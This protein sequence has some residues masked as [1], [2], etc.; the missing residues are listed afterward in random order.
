MRSKSLLILCVLSLVLVA[1]VVNTF[2]QL[3]LTRLAFLGFRHILFRILIDTVKSNLGSPKEIITEKII[4]KAS[5]ELEI[6]VI[7]IRGPFNPI[8]EDFAAD[9]ANA[10]NDEELQ[11]IAE[12]YASRLSDTLSAEIEMVKTTRLNVEL[13]VSAVSYR[14][15]GQVL[16]LGASTNDDGHIQHWDLGR[17]TLMKRVHGHNGSVTA[18]DYH[19]N[20]QIYASGS[21]DDTVHIRRVSNDSLIVTLNH[22][23]NVKPV[24]FSRDGNYLLAL[25]VGR[26][27]HQALKVWRASDWSQLYHIP[28]AMISNDAAFTSDSQHVIYS[29]E[30]S[31]EFLNLQT[32]RVTRTLP[33]RFSQQV[34]ISSDGRKLAYP[35]SRDLVIWD[36][37]KNERITSINDA[38]DGAIFGLEFLPNDNLL[39]SS[40]NRKLIKIWSVADAEL[41]AVFQPTNLFPN[42]IDVSPNGRQ[43]ALGCYNPGI[44]R[45]E[46]YLFDVA[47]F[48]NWLSPKVAVAPVE[49]INFPPWDVNQ[50][51][52]VDIGDIVLV[53]QEFG[54][55][56]PSNSRIDVNNDGIV[57]IV[58]IVLIGQ[59]FGE[60]TTTAAPQ[61]ALREQSEIK[62]LQRVYQELL[63]APVKPFGYEKT[64][65]LLEGIFGLIP[66]RQTRLLANYPN[67]FNPET[68]IPYQLAKTSYVMIHI[69]ETNGRRV[70]TLDLGR[71]GAGHYLTKSQAA[72]W[73]GKTTLGQP[74]SSGVYF[75]SIQVGDFT[76]TIKMV[77]VK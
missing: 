67:P 54:Q 63:K 77:I 12:Q 51:G 76:E 61:L 68:W 3:T 62:I 22:I 48:A 58:D 33:E 1:P 57:D 9:A 32:G 65:A 6:P 41:L 75:Y 11:R 17:K 50:D 37:E 5:E 55:R 14:P 7:V 53:G 28:V 73:D 2:S 29:T 38:L 4:Q 40:D 74:V 66:P 15:S 43:I 25:G 42:D 46:V 60:K 18:L 20:G 31:I 56:N 23:G 69:Y 70:R 71:Q 72:H 34:A 49:I 64:R 21:R 26:G 59:H 16:T 44:S 39:I 8:V 13:S 19:P 30:D 24:A 52:V 45:G 35:K 27:G 47:T 10:A 36:L